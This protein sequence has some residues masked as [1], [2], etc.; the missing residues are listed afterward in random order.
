MRKNI[1]M[2]VPVIVISI[3]ICYTYVVACGISWS[4]SNMHAFYGINAKGEVDIT[5][6]VGYIDVDEENQIDLSINFNSKRRIAS[7]LFGYGWWFGLIDSYVVKDTKDSY[8]F[9]MPSGQEIILKQNYDDKKIFETNRKNWILEEI[10][11]GFSISGSCGVILTYK[12]NLLDQIKYS[13]GTILSFKYEGSRLKH[14]RVKNEPIL[15][16]RYDKD[17]TIY[18]DFIRERQTI[19]FRLSEVSG[20]GKLLSEYV[21]FSDSKDVKKYSYK[22]SDNNTNEL[23]ITHNDEE[24][25]YLWESYTG[26][27]LKEK[28]YKDKR[29]VDSY[30]YTITNRDEKD[31]YKYLKRKSNV[32]KKEDIFYWN[33]N[34]ISVRQNNSGDI[35]TTY[36]NMNATC[37][38]KPRK[39]VTQHSDGKIDED[40]FLYDDKGRIIREIKNGEVLYNVKRN[41]NERSITYYDGKWKP[42]WK[43]VYEQQ[44]RIVYYEKSD[45][46]KTIFRYLEDGKI[47][48]T[49]TKN[50]KTITKLFNENLTIIK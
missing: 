37:Y 41:D 39:I 4:V 22:F 27:I 48:A 34:G 23:S 16:F 50:G 45:G 20:Y 11:N 36:A 12:R 46:S 35:V 32:S 10:P 14:I 28:L 26:F 7:K 17:N 15:S 13:N 31:V 3:F 49:L 8:K 30:E 44:N 29:L 43:K 25:I 9:V 5:E 38:G 18:I 19:R 21:D 47:E 6:A 42:I 40:L 2:K 24:K 1:K 33:E